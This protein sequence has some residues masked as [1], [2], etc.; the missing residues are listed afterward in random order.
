MGSRFDLRNYCT[1]GT[2]RKSQPKSRT[3][4]ICNLCFLVVFSV[5]AF[6]LG[7]FGCHSI[8]LEPAKVLYLDRTMI[9]TLHMTMEVLAGVKVEVF[10]FLLAACVHYFLFSNRL[11][12][13]ESGLH[14]HV[15]ELDNGRRVCGSEMNK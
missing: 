10:V 2:G 9:E 6:F 3:R 8:C 13:K 7:T 1:W 12:L 5:F 15:T 4:T 14:G 11:P